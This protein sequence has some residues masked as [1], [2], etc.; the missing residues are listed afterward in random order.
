MEEGP[1]RHM[2]TQENR[3]IVDAVFGM[4]GM[5]GAVENGDKRGLLFFAK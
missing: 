1:V 4:A 5:K 3:F 2:Q